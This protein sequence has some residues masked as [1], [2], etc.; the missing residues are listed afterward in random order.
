MP[1]ENEVARLPIPDRLVPRNVAR[2]LQT[3]VTGYF[4]SL[5]NS[6]NATFR[7]MLVSVGNK[8][9]VTGNRMFDRHV[10]VNLIKD[11]AKRADDA[12]VLNANVSDGDIYKCLVNC[13]RGHDELRLK[14]RREQYERLTHQ[15][16]AE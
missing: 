1:T 7:N 15:Q 12:I 11:A 3:N 2:S 14:L 9:A 4:Y 13:M 16:A 10:A 8:D 6:N 5:Y